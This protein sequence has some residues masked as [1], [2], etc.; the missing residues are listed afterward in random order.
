M[1]RR[2][3]RI[4]SRGAAGL[5]PLGPLSQPDTLALVSASR[6][7][8]RRPATEGLGAAGLD[9]SEGNPLVV[10]EMMREM[11]E[12]R[13]E[14]PG[15]AA[16]RARGHRPSAGAAGRGQQ[17]L[18]TVA[19]VIGREF[20]FALLRHAARL[21]DEEA[22]QGVEELVRRRILTGVG[23]RLDFTHERV[24]EVAYAELPAWRRA[25]ASPGRGDDRG[26]LR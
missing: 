6:R 12:R 1:L 19:A 26:P 20:E 14:G 18:L 21:D 11:Q 7:P 2:T 15:S 24:R 4:L 17:S 13:R 8:E 25:P 23:E 16:A 9:V 3:S 5:A 10:V 22:A